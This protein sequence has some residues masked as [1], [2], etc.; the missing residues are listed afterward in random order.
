MRW[1]CGK[2]SLACSRARAWPK[3]NKSKTPVVLRV[4]KGEGGGGGDDGELGLREKLTREAF[5]LFH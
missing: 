1:T 4:K 2:R 5:S 3:W